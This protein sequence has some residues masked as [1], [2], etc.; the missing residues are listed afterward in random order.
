MTRGF[1]KTGMISAC[2]TVL[3]VG[4]A[5]PSAAFDSID[6]LPQ[7]TDSQL[8]SSVTQ[9]EIPQATQFSTENTVRSFAEE[10]E[11]SWVLATDIL[12]KPDAYDLPSGAGTKIADLLGDVPQG[13]TLR[14]EGHTDSRTGE[15][16]NQELSEKRAQAV[17]DAIGEERS[18][19]TLETTG[20]GPDEPA[21]T[22]QEGEEDTFAANRRVEL[23]IED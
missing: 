2:A 4:L 17:A 1:F 9:F 19:L 13:A 3:I 10:E 7:P 5:G 12:F 22:E 15:I 16:P 8:R 6:E 20:Y 14:V 11:D 21:V 23:I 18:D